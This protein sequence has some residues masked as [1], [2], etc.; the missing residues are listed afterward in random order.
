MRK[1]SFSGFIHEKPVKLEVGQM[2]SIMVTA[3][4][5]RRVIK[6]SEDIDVLIKS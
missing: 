1:L 6:K 5:G 3:C 2:M 4:M